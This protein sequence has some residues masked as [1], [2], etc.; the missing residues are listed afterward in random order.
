[1]ILPLNR[2]SPRICGDYTIKGVSSPLLWCYAVVLCS[3]TS[4]KRSGELKGTGVKKYYVFDEPLPT[5]VDDFAPL[6]DANITDPRFRRTNTDDWYAAIKSRALTRMPTFG[7][8]YKV[9][10]SANYGRD[11]GMVIFERARSEATRLSG[12]IAWMNKNTLA[13]NQLNHAIDGATFMTFEKS[14]VCLLAL[15]ALVVE[16]IKKFK[17][18]R[19]RQGEKLSSLE[20]GADAA[21]AAAQNSNEAAIADLKAQIQSVDEKL[22]LLHSA[23]LGRHSII[24][25]CFYF[26]GIGPAV[27]AAVAA[28]THGSLHDLTNAVAKDADQPYNVVRNLLGDTTE[29][30]QERAKVD[31]AIKHAASYPTMRAVFK[32]LLA[33]P[34]CKAVIGS[35][36]REDFIQRVHVQGGN[37][38]AIDEERMIPPQK[39]TRP[40][41]DWG[42]PAKG[43]E[44]YPPGFEDDE[45]QP[46]A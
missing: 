28:G 42:S 9:Y 16:D 39:I 44:P 45:P 38:L 6:L 12:D 20:A 13:K 2:L 27:A 1:M 15:N 26:Y 46:P 32:T 17:R 21:D 34:A 41:Y 36:N 25:S 4:A 19:T 40:P 30:S 23:L 8:A 37:K 31:R 35:T 14:V 5:E 43:E 29:T 3:R 7:D 22:A 10:V 18:D 11:E 33:I 24:I